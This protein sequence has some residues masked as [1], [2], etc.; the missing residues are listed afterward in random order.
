[1]IEPRLQFDSLTEDLDPV[2]SVILEGQEAFRHDLPQLLREHARH[3]VA[4]H[5]RTRVGLCSSKNKLF[6]L[7]LCAG[8]KRGE[9]LVR[10][11]EAANLST[12][13]TVDASAEIPR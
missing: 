3:W 5:G 2:P 7:L 11:I 8:Y 13:Q 10:R 9:L 6:D 1:M 4:Y 12:S